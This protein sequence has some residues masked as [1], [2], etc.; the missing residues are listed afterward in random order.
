MAS[1]LLALLG[2][3]GSL[4]ASLGGSNLHELLAPPV[5]QPGDACW[6]Q[7]QGSALREGGA[8]WAPSSE[9]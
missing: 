9:T 6:H 8:L 4:T 1:V 5:C 3:L 7:A 2:P